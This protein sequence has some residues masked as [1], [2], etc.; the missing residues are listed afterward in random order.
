M[1][2]RCVPFLA[3]VSL[4]CGSSPRAG[5]CGFTGLAGASMLLQQFGV[6]EQTLGQPP[7][8]LPPR[9]VA[10]LA[11][12]PALAAEVGRTPDSAWII[13]VVGS[14]PAST[15]P[16]FGVLVLDRQ[17]KARGVAVY[18]SEPVRGAP[19]IGTLVVDTLTMPLLGLAADSASYDTPGC[20]FFPDSVLR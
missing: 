17:G 19:R 12:G 4:A 20:P 14:L 2:A 18:E 15:K 9:L 10:R 11:A 3:I 1:R 7:V 16:R 8:S 13:G 6:P 5:P